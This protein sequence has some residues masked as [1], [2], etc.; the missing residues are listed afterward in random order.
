M[1]VP[2]VDAFSVL[3]GPAKSRAPTS[4]KPL[5]D[6]EKSFDDTVRDGVPKAGKAETG[7]AEDVN[8]DIAR[9]RPDSE[10]TEDPDAVYQEGADRDRPTLKD[11]E[12]EADAPVDVVADVAIAVD[13]AKPQSPPQL[14]L[15]GTV[16]SEAKGNGTSFSNPEVVGSETTGNS[17]IIVT[18]GTS[19][20]PLGAQ[21]ARGGELPFANPDGVSQAKAGLE[22]PRLVSAL[23][24][25]K[26]SV[27]T[28]T[29]QEG[30]LGG[31]SPEDPESPGLQ[32]RPGASIALPDDAVEQPALRVE[33]QGRIQ[34]TEGTQPAPLASQVTPWR[35]VAAQPGQSDKP[36][37]REQAA[38]ITPA[39]PPQTGASAPVAS[40]LGQP[41]V[42]GA[43][44]TVVQITS[45]SSANTIPQDAFHTFGTFDGAGQDLG[46]AAVLRE[47][48][49]AQPS[50]ARADIAGA[51]RLPA[52]AQV[53]QQLI[54]ASINLSD[55]PVELTLEPAELGKVRMMLASS[56][57]GV[58]VVVSAE[59][60]E[61]LD[62]LRRNIGLLERDF[63]EIGYSNIAFD[64]GTSSGEGQQPRDRDAGPSTVFAYDAAGDGPH[65]APVAAT[66]NQAIRVDDRLDIRL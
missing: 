47:G 54:A 26:P 33:P 14:L 1:S 27:P 19:D 32:A 42:P 53:V 22:D 46:E 38:E 23:D 37:I 57:S 2:S 34:G 58:S 16:I 50:V 61:T 66:Q 30:S 39:T 20:D 43:D 64:F 45:L 7:K 24:A 52:P 15:A 44:A 62:L 11:T 8:D 28:P 63:R 51:A 3:P 10:T 36:R 49:G 25:K 6:T 5:Q 29:P 60:Q 59:R 56:E 65:V 40:F 31:G 9:P 18:S 21:I 41:T 48:R 17:K 55:R 12:V 35:S 13:E 4:Q